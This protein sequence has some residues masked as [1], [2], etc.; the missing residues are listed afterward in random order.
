MGIIAEKE[1]V[2][3]F[4]EELLIA[5]L[6]M[7]IAN[8][9][10]NAVCANSAELNLVITDEQLGGG[11]LPRHGSLLACCRLGFER[12]VSHD[13]GVSLVHS[14]QA[15]L[16]ARVILGPNLKPQLDRLCARADDGFGHL[17]LAPES[18]RPKGKR[19]DNRAGGCCRACL[20]EVPT[21]LF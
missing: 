5:Y 10:G 20:A 13:F 15:G 14:L 1:S 21:I 2:T 16:V 3:W 18:P 7:V 6:K 17:S 4:M 19:N 9:V 11:H 8:V 12:T